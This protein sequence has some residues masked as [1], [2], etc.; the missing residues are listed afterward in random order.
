MGLQ[1]LN[2]LQ[3]IAHGSV[4]NLFAFALLSI[5]VANTTELRAENC[6]SL[7]SA[8]RK[9]NISAKKNILTDE[10]LVKI[11]S[12]YKNDPQQ[13]PKFIFETLLRKE[14]TA[15]HPEQKRE[16]EAFFR[17]YKKISAPGFQGAL[18]HRMDESQKIVFEQI[19]V[20]IPERYRSTEIEYLFKLHEFI[21]RIRL[22]QVKKLGFSDPESYKFLNTAKGAYQHEL[23]AM[24][25]EWRYLQAI[26]TAI[27]EELARQIASEN[28]IL[29]IDKN[30][31]LKVLLSKASTQAEY[32]REIQKSRHY[33]Y[34]EL[35]SQKQNEKREEWKYLLAKSSAA[36][37][38]TGLFLY[39]MI[40]SWCYK[41]VNPNGTFP[42]TELFKTFCIDSPIVGKNIKDLIERAKKEGPNFIH[43]YD[44][45]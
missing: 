7:Y 27:R 14:L 29:D 37:A 6:T 43:H 32:V 16:L 15:L 30:V 38:S 19:E 23:S 24:Q 12:L 40:D 39:I 10:D 22:A 5:A 42:D 4:L 33:S 45:E 8:F 18:A 35:Y 17:K 9:I 41:N 26:P 3:K 36:A 2:R 13:A 1:S 31:P 44:D 28:A 20:A 21:H 25:S 34:R 11:S